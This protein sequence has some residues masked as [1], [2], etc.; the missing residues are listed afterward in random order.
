M[1]SNHKKAVIEE[2]IKGQ[3]TPWYAFVVS[4]KRRELITYIYPLLLQSYMRI[5]EYNDLKKM[6]R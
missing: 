4:P 1:F 3:I 6:E 2:S 5:L